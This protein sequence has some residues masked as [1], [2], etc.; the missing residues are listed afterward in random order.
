[1][2]FLFLKHNSEIFANSYQKESLIDFAQSFCLLFSPL[3]YLIQIS[4]PSSFLHSNNPR[5][6]VPTASFPSIKLQGVNVTKS[7]H[8]LTYKGDELKQPIM[9]K[10]V[11]KDEKSACSF[12]VREF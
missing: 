6:P 8:V 3:S 2:P 11:T 10:R 7:S 1:M 12:I 9:E 4:L 5:D